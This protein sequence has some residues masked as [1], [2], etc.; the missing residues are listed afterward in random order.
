MYPCNF[1]QPN[2]VCVAALDQSYALA[3]F[4]DWGSTSVDVGAP[5]TNI[6]STYAGTSATIQDSL[7]SGWFS[8][9]G[10]WVYSTWA[11]GSGNSHNI[12]AD[13]LTWPA[14][15]YPANVNDHVY[16]T[17]DLSAYSTAFLHFSLAGVVASGDGFNFRTT[18]SGGDPFATTGGGPLNYS[19]WTPLTFDITTCRTATC[20]IG[21]QLWSGASSPG[22]MGPALRSF[23][24]DT[25]TLNATS[26]NTIDGT[27]MASP[28]VAGLATMLRAYNPQY[29]YTDVV[30]AI[31]SAGRPVP[32]LSGK[33]T[34]GKAIDVMASLAYINAPTGLV[35]VVQ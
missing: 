14:G 15:T 4:S 30:S 1:S 20:S 22:A 28:E 24:I 13:P 32:G 21:F 23:S 8:N 18:G 2:L 31:T 27:S 12:L 5:G 10:A 35:A 9:G 7:N 6:L 16:K 33:T 26:Y 25:L 3:S 11:D 17:F 29:T 34:T 19:S